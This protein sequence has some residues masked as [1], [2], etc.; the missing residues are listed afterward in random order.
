MKALKYTIYEISAHSILS[1]AI[2]T[3][4]GY[5]FAFDA[6]EP[7]KECF[8]EETRQDDCPIFYQAMRILGFNAPFAGVSDQ[9]RDVFVYIDFS[10]IFD[11]SPV[12]KALEAQEKAEYMFR[13]EGIHLHF[14]RGESRYLAFERSAS[15]SRN[16][17][18][19]FVREDVY[20]CPSCTP[21][22]P[23]SLPRA[24]D[25]AIRSCFSRTGSPS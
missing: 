13:P 5:R 22:M 12:G 19:S 11:R 21:T 7:S 23:C 24:E 17:R 14:G 25:T 10:G 18:I 2:K 9:L 4:D 15:M 20:D 3:E 16:S 6:T 1:A 8:L